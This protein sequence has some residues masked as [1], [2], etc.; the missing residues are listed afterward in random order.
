MAACRPV[1]GV[2]ER[3]WIDGGEGRAV[4]RL[5]QRGPSSAGIVADI[6]AGLIR[7]ISFGYS[8]QRY[9]IS[10]RPRPHPTA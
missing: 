3:G 4:I 6:R 5:S 2:A 8:V 7:A 10:P 1:L 9:E